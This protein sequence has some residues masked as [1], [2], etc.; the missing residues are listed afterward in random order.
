[1][2]TTTTLTVL[3][4]TLM[5]ICTGCAS[6]FEVPLYGCTKVRHVLCHE[7]GPDGIHIG[8]T[9][10]ELFDFLEE[11]GCPW[12]FEWDHSRHRFK[13]AVYDTYTCSDLWSRYGDCYVT[14]TFRNNRL[15]EWSY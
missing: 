1:M 2:K 12:N 5:L 3:L 14:F 13:T 4:V 7:T 15:I 10:Q 8:M 9:S 6:L 11:R